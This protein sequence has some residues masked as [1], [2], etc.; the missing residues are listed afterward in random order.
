[1]YPSFKL[2]NILDSIQGIGNLLH[3]NPY[4]IDFLLIAT[5]FVWNELFFV[6]YDNEENNIHFVAKVIKG[7]L[8][9]FKASGT[10]G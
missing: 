8:T 1:M 10:T 5:R 7:L 6:V 4:E 9:G 3:M 2:K